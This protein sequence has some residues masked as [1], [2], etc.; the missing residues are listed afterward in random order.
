MMDDEEGYG[1]NLGDQM[2][3]ELASMAQ[4]YKY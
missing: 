4:M 3:K 2:Y 1:D